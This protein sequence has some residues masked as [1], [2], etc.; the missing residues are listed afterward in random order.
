MRLW[1]RPL[2]LRALQVPTKGELWIDEKASTVSLVANPPVVLDF[3][4]AV[5]ERQEWNRELPDRR[6]CEEGVLSWQ[7]SGGEGDDGDSFVDIMNGITA[8]SGAE[9]EGWTFA[10]ALVRGS[11]LVGT[12]AQGVIDTSQ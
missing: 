5:R 8:D 3:H 9:S 10:E 7:E 1:W 12:L 4:I 11:L 2:S 6:I